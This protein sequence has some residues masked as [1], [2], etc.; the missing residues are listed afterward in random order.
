MEVLDELIAHGWTDGALRRIDE[1]RVMQL[2]SPRRTHIWARTY[3]QRAE[4]LIEEGRMHPAGL[5]AIQYAKE[6]GTWEE[7]QHVDDLRVPDDLAAELASQR[8]AVAFDSFPPSHRRNV[9]RWLAKAK[10]A[11]TRRRRIVE[12]AARAASGE[13]VPGL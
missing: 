12:I 2:V 3:Q 9:L 8:S 5:A 11:D 7:H 4:R 6:R 10:R 13:R 1:D